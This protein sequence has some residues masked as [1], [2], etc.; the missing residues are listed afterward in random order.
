[1]PNA[2]VPVSNESM[3]ALQVE[4]PN[5][6][7]R[8]KRHRKSLKKR[9][10]E[11]MDSVP[12]QLFLGLLLILSLFLPDIWI[13]CN[14]SSESDEALY[15]ILLVVFIIFIFETVILTAVQDD[16]FLSFFFWMD[17]IGTLSIILDIGWIADSFMPDNTDATQKG[18]LLRAARAAKLGARYGRLMRLLKL[19]RFFKFLPCFKQEEDVEPEPTMSAVRKVSSELSS[20]LSRRVA[21]LVM[22]IVIVVPF[23]DY[24][25]VDKSVDAWLTNFRR[26][27][28]SNTTTTD[29]LDSMARKFRRFYHTEALTPLQLTVE[30]AHLPLFNEHY[31][32]GYKLRNDNKILYEMSF[33]DND[34]KY[35]VRVKM[36][37]TVIRQWDAF[38]GIMLIILVIVVLVGFSASFQNSVDVL[39]VVPLEKMMNTL[40]RSATAMLK[41]MQA[42]DKED[43]EN[44]MG[45][46]SDLDQEL[47][48]AVLEKMVEKLARIVK[49]VTNDNDLVVDENVDSAVASWLTQNYAGNATKK[50]DVIVKDHP[51]LSDEEQQN[52]LRDLHKSVD[53]KVVNSWNFDVLKYDYEQLFEYNRYLFDV[54][55]VFAQFDIPVAVMDAFMHELSVRYIKDNTYHNFHHACDVTQTTYRLIMV[56]KVHI[57]LSDL[58]AFSMLVAAM[59]HDVGHPG[60]NNAFL[61]K[62]RHDLAMIHNDKSPLENMHCS[63]LYEL[64]RKPE[65]NI[66]AGLP[67]CQWRESRKIILSLILGTDMAHHFDQ[68]SKTQLF[69]EVNGEDVKKFCYGHTD[70][71]ECF[72]EEKNRIFIMELFLHCADISNPYKPFEIC[73]QWADLVSQEFFSQGD[74][75][76]ASGMDVSPMMDRETSN[77][78]N[79]QMGFIEFVVSPLVNTVVTL[80]PPLKETGEMMLSNYIQ[81]G[82][83]RK[84]EIRG[85]VDM[86]AD[87]KDEE[88]KKVDDRISKFKD[89]MAFL[90]NIVEAKRKHSSGSLASNK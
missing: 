58:E 75:E 55:N 56:S 10:F 14:A 62:P 39:V 38:F 23:L 12:M 85:T 7:E 60:V 19:M 33:L 36:N 6:Y 31:S 72:G 54:F 63:L 24:N 68:V 52:K 1:M 61:V 69:L 43:E 59:G 79:M 88:V 3:Q 82:E 22:L 9:V 53:P 67:D 25:I 83:K 35:W 66:M 90:S 8:P 15:S 18:S 29:D 27:A 77:L 81:W 47:E 87:K 46:N 30:T 20:V 71:I 32:Q 4:H 34:E 16:Y 44:M 86:A 74:K 17:F 5:Q 76:R 40:R 11:V 49:H 57:A 78:F 2:V 84:D 37:N 21:A 42:M 51:D 28:Y 80:F 89:K 50:R 64:F 26:V 65:F 41:S 48:T 73:A 70:T 45:E 13:L